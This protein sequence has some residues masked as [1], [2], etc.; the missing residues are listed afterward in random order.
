MSEMKHT[1]G[2]WSSNPFSMTGAV[3]AENEFIASVYPNAPKGWDG[4]SA[5]HRSDE[6]KA[7]AQ[8]I[9]A[10]P[11]LLAALKEVSDWINNWSPDFIMD[12]EWPDTDEKL[13]AAIARAEGRS[14]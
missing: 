10:A 11:D 14:K 9:A 5:Y 6:M 2:P 8:L 12:E 1:P 3:W 4:L 7:N 13:R